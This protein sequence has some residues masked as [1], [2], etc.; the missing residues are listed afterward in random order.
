MSQFSHRVAYMLSG[1][2]GRCVRDRKWFQTLIECQTCLLL[3]R[4]P[5]ESARAISH[6]Y[7]V[8]YS[9]PGLTTEFLTGN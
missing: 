2:A 1:L 5:M 7:D 8:G 9:E 6:F 4:F 3:Y